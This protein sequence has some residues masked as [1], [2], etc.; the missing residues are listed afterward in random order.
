MKVIS[1]LLVLLL[2]IPIF[3]YGRPSPFYPWI[4]VKD[5]T[6]M[7]SSHSFDQ[8]EAIGYVKGPKRSIVLMRNPLGIIFYLTTGKTLGMENFV[9]SSIQDQKGYTKL[10]FVKNVQNINGEQVKLIRHKQIVK[11]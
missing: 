7:A 4:T 5:S 2:L 3:S 1:R 8:Y 6:K 11:E 9:L 10:T